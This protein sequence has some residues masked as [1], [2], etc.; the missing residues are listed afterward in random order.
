[1]ADVLAYLAR[2]SATVE[3][4]VSLPGRLSRVNR[5]IDVLVRGK[6][7]DRSD[8]TLVVDAKRWS[9]HSRLGGVWWWDPGAVALTCRD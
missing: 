5:Q 4:N 2:A 3:R 6:I 1:M 8:T 7:Y 9:K